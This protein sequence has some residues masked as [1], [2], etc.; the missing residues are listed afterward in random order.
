MFNPK[1]EPF[2]LRRP[3]RLG[4]WSACFPACLFFFFYWIHTL[5]FSSPLSS[6]CFQH[7]FE[8]TLW[9]LTEKNG[10]KG[11]ANILCFLNK[12]RTG[13]GFCC[14][15]FVLFCF[16]RKDRTLTNDSSEIA[17]IIFFLL[18][19]QHSNDLLQRQSQKKP[20]RPAR[21][22]GKVFFTTHMGDMRS[23]WMDQ[24][25]LWEVM[26]WEVF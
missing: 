13:S 10:I 3:I 22:R 4:F 7:F 6:S 8:N 1:T 14:V 25:F 17:Q 21:T 16:G 15:Y 2:L 19:S 18:S 11:L 5:Y 12:G 20:P 23:L 9:I 26:R 24:C